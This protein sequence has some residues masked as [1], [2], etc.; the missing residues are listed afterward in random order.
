VPTEELINV[1]GSVVKEDHIQQFRTTFRGELIRPGEEGYENARKI[2]NASVDK[3]PG[4]VARCLGV[5][6]VVAAV[7]FA[8]ENELLVA[9]RGG[10]HNV[11]GR[12][13]CDG[14]LVIDLSRMKDIHVD[15]AKRTARVL[16]GATLGEVDRETHVFGLAVLAGIVSRTGIAGLTLGGGVGWL[17][18]KFGMT[19]DNVLSFET[20]TADGKVLTASADENDDLFWA[21]RGG[22]GNF[23]VVASFQ[24]RAHAVG[25]CSADCWFI[26]APP[27]CRCSASSATSCSQLLTNSPPTPLCCTHPTECQWWESFPAIAES[28]RKASACSSHSEDLG[29]PYWT[30]SSLC[31]FPPCNRYWMPF[32][33]TAI[34]TTGNRPCN[35][36]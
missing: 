35:R 27:P 12:A 26:R 30:R 21:L 6:D 22:G 24:F 32:S 18:R 14:G 9:V 16:G 34:T 3:H 4:I 36:N 19:I 2:W 13:L 7:N 8:R 5:A 11:G 1:K 17:M 25:L 33:W 15:P 28:L 10:G 31:P 23:G 29:R 20:V